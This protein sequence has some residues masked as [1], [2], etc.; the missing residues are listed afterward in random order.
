MRYLKEYNGDS[1][2]KV[3]FSFSLDKESF[4][5][6]SEISFLIDYLKECGLLYRFL[7]NIQTKK[8][9]D[10]KL[11]NPTVED[12]IHCLCIYPKDMVIYVRKKQNEWFSVN[13]F[14][15]IGYQYCYKCDQV[16]G[17]VDLLEDK[18][19]GKK[20]MLKESAQSIQQ[21]TLHDFNKFH[22]GRNVVRFDHRDIY[23][24]ESVSMEVFG[25][26]F[27]EIRERRNVIDIV[28]ANRKAIT[29][30]KYQDDWYVLQRPALHDFSGRQIRP[31]E[32]YKCDQL[33]SLIEFIRD[34]RKKLVN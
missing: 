16:G 30:Y 23:E 33:D 1:Y 3:D 24:I 19:I 21:M 14:T 27:R 11:V 17:V 25:K 29:I 31:N 8:G 28:L 18:I 12:K 2:S 9:F 32:Y 13:I 20:T 7:K 5:D 10:D 15:D 4:F 34:N 22:L 6:M 26:S